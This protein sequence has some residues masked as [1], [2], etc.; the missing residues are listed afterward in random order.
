MLGA[1]MGVAVCAALIWGVDS[2][3]KTSFY[4]NQGKVFGTYYS[5]QYEATNDLEDSIQAAFVAFD[6][7]LSMFNPQSTLSAINHNRDTTTDEYFETM[8][9]EAKHVD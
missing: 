2:D 4:K 9:T 8:W 3:K 6:N 1:L 7:S 5:I